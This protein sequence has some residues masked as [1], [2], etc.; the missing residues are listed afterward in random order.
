[1]FLLRL[2][3][4]Q[5]R[6][7]QVHTTQTCYARLYAYP[8]SGLIILTILCMKQYKYLLVHIDLHKILRPPNDTTLGALPALRSS[9]KPRL[10]A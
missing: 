9:P 6:V 8:L 1:M 2:E 10:R 4:G 7:P 5:N 3:S